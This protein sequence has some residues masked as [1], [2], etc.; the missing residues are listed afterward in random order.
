VTDLSDWAPRPRPERR[1]H[2]GRYVRLEPLDSARH[3]DELFEAGPTSDALLRYLPERPFPDRASFQPWLDK[4][5]ASEDPLFFAA[6]DKTSGRAEGRLSLMRIDPANGVIE[7]GH[8]LFGPRLSRSRGATEAIYLLG[9]HVFDELG[10]RRFEWKCN[11]LN[12][13]SKRAAI[14]FGFVFE[15]VFRQHMVV[16]GGNRDT[17]WYSI[18]DSE[19]PARRRAFERW[20][21]PAN[22][23]E[24]GR[25]RLS[26]SALNAEFFETGDPQLR[27]RLAGPRDLAA[28]GEFQRAAYAPNRAILGLEPLPLLF[29]YDQVLGRY[30]TWLADG[31]GGLS[32]ALILDPHPDHL[33]IW[34]LATA[35]SAQRQGLGAR[36]LAAAEARARQLGLDT[37]RLYTG[38]KLTGN[39]R[40]YH[41]HG[42][43]IERVE[44]LP[45]RRL[46]HMT[47]RI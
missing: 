47:K 15:G 33:L 45:D 7:T 9:R 25:Q 21:D 39:V 34:S 20:L 27:L 5:A 19:W 6:V 10:Y 29:D 17:A 36:L 41:R 35:P 37:L 12:E 8:L 22:F 1:A 16:K 26:L 38:E 32:G 11:D 42:Y 2:E 30:E 3:G 40:W 46:V 14:R 31:D 23:D 13:P 24:S 43:A 4:A 28:L 18:I 44:E